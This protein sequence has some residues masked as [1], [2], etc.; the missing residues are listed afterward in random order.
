MNTL[1]KTLCFVLL[2]LPFSTNALA[3]NSLWLGAKVGTL[4]LGIEGTWQP[5]PWLDLRA[6]LNQYDYDDTGSQ[7]GIN[8]DGELGLD[9]VYATANFRFP[10]SPMRLT[11]G[12]F[13]NNNEL[14]LSSQDSA[15]FELGGTTYSSADVGTLRSSTSFED[16]APY[17]GVGFDFDVF[18]KVGLTLDFGVLWQGDP[19]VTLTADGLLANDPVFLDALESE[20]VELEAEVDDF[21][22]WPV[23]SIGFNFSFL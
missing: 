11:A 23:I 4:G 1:R 19:A 2:A 15:T 3:D 13:G 16:T 8:Y 18:N 14:T 21:K 22:A 12:I 5:I 9:T 17:L 20:R 10:L 7:A 6:G